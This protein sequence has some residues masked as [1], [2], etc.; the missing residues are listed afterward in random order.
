M[1]SR[2]CLIGAFLSLVCVTNAFLFGNS[3]GLNSKLCLLGNINACPI[4]TTTGV[5]PTYSYST[6]TSPP[7]YTTSSPTTTTATTP[8]ATATA[9]ATG[10]ATASRAFNDNDDNDDNEDTADDGARAIRTTRKQQVRRVQPYGIR[11]TV[12]RGKLVTRRR[13]NRTG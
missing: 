10:T 8:T 3:S 12:R 4:T 5:T 1:T 9:T 11:R 7:A 6:I 2:A 13:R